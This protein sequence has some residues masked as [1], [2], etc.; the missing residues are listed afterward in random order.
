M[1]GT[2]TLSAD[3][4][5]TVIGFLEVQPGAQL[6]IPAGTRL[7][8]DPNSRGSIVTV[9]CAGGQPSGRLVVNG[10]EGDP[11]VFGPPGESG[12]QRGQAGGIVL[13]GCAPIN[14]V[15]GTGTSEG[16]GRPFGGTD[17]T[18]SS[19]EIHYLVIEFGGVPVAPD[20][21]INGLTFAGTG[22]G[23]VIDHVQ[24]HFIADDGF[25]WFGG[26]TNA[27]FLV[28]SG[29]DDDGLDCDNGWDGTV[30]FSFVIQ[31]AQLANRGLECDN[32]ASGS[33]NTPITIPTFWNGTWVGAGVRVANADVNDGLY[34]RRN[35]AGTY[36]NG[37]V[38]N[39]GNV[40]IVIDGDGSFGQLTS[41]ALDIDNFLF[42]GNK[43]LESGAVGT[44]DLTSNVQRRSGSPAAYNASGL[45]GPL[46][47]S[48]FVFADAQLTSVNLG[49]PIDGTQPNPLPAAGSP[50]LDAANAATPTGDG[51]V[52]G[53]ADFLGAF[54]TD[55]WIDGWTAWETD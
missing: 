29:N 30:Q 54:G 11:V 42:F 28:S 50:A 41:G 19:G 13:H 5:Y 25:E 6:I 36:R 43:G 47:A 4:I 14:L 46:A 22:S 26:S 33:S 8:S 24:T 2:R 18:D 53:S 34:I 20:N 16:V 32:D 27:S 44:D 10:T 52:D 12:R 37:L 48:T 40:G 1:L 3:T 7:V 31:D 23:T 17:P 55:N 21:E 49:D 39:F 38:T 15:G 45:P 51:I 9:R 35:S